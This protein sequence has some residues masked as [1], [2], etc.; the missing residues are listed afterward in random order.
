MSA[1]YEIHRVKTENFFTVVNCCTAGTK[2]RSAFCCPFIAEII[3]HVQRFVVLRPEI[4]SPCSTGP[5]TIIAN[6]RFQVRRAVGLLYK[7][8]LHVS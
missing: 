5:L 1:L 6:S 2:E 8:A 7:L 4:E 3:C